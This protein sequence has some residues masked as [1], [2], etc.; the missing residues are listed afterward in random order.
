[1][2]MF[3]IVIADDEPIIRMDIREILELNG[4]EVVGEASDGIEAVETCRNTKP[5]LVLMDIKMPMLD[6]LKA[7][8]L[9]HQQKLARCALMLTA[10][11]EKHMLEQA[12]NADVMGYLIKPVE[13]KSLIPAI[14]IALAKQSKI[15]KMHREYE[16]TRTALESRKYID[17]AKGI[18]MEKKKMS[19][20]EAYNYMRK[21]AMDRECTIARI[22]Q[23][24][25][26]SNQ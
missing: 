22:A 9:I 23:T 17:R 24:I 14:E 1:M 5:D 11:N 18:L 19:E 7:A 6:G 12:K 13:E 2:K 16:K 25:I 3:R 10:Y 26:L 21:V 15:E 4:Y 20:W 8:E